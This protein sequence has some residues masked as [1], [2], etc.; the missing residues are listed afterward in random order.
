ML[1]IL[2]IVAPIYIVILIG[3]AMT[4]SGLFAKADMRVFGKFVINLAL[5][6]LLFR[7]LSQR[8]LGDVLN[9]G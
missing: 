4:R 9:V 8:Q 3:F 6:V 7:A 2:A 1:A 5:P